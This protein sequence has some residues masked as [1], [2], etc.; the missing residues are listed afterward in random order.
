MMPLI[1]TNCVLFFIVFNYIRLLFSY[2]KAS[3]VGNNNVSEMDIMRENDMKREQNS[4]IMVKAL[5]DAT[6][7]TLRE[8]CDMLEE[9]ILREK[10]STQSSNDAAMRTLRERCDMLEEMIL[11]ESRQ[12]RYF[13]ASF[14]YENRME[15]DR[16]IMQKKEAMKTSL[17]MAYYNIY[18]LEKKKIK[19]FPEEKQRVCDIL[20]LT[21]L[22]IADKIDIGR[23][24][25]YRN[26]N[27]LFPAVTNGCQPSTNTFNNQPYIENDNVYIRF[28]R[29]DTD[30]F[31]AMH[32]LRTHVY[33]ITTDT[34][35][36]EKKQ[37]MELFLSSTYAVTD[38]DVENTR[39]DE[40]NKIL[41]A[42]E[43]PPDFP[44]I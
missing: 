22:S 38:V 28:C 41:Y 42:L 32:S 8:R 25:S 13:E 10:A 5:C 26:F 11:D 9:M 18:V 24:L 36:L 27:A 34:H 19:D 44:K 16:E 6:M 37:S 31:G 17:D 43:Q 33:N 12:S 14:R 21:N 40:R 1:V 20:P 39:L 23:I 29:Y 7:R 30:G 4:E 2:V 15:D 3:F 35:V